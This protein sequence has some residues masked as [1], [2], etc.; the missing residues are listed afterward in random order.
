MNDVSF[1]ANEI[2]IIAALLGTLTMPLGVLF[3]SLRSSYLD[4]IADAREAL[5]ES[6]RR[7]DDLRPSIEKMADIL[8]SQTAMLERLIEVRER[9]AR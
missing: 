9:T 7:N 4:R 2:A 1:S 6:R 8:R 5:T 3:W